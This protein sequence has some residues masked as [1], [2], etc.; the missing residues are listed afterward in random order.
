[1]DTGPRKR[2]KTKG[3]ER[4]RNLHKW[5]HV[6]VQYSTHVAAAVPD[7]IDGPPGHSIRR[8]LK[9]SDISLLVSFHM[10]AFSKSMFNANTTF[11]RLQN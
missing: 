3:G 9:V 7:R 6:S 8:S 10:F 1:M 2:K 11:R 4:E 5:S